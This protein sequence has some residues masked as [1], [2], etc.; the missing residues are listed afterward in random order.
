MRLGERDIPSFFSAFGEK[1]KKGEDSFLVIFDNE[2]ESTPVFSTS[3]TN[4]RMVA[5]ISNFDL[6]RLEIA[7]G[8]E[9]TFFNETEKHFAEKTLVVS[10]VLRDHTGISTLKLQYKFDDLNDDKHEVDKYGY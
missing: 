4:D 10:L 6:N 3:V 2:A 1:M 7:Q 8:D 9:M 5:L